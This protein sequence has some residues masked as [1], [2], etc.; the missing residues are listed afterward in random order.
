MKWL[1]R[2]KRFFTLA[3]PLMV[4]AN[5]SL[6]QAPPPLA[7]CTA[8]QVAQAV[9]P[10]YAPTETGGFVRIE[11]GFFSIAGERFVA[12]GVN[13]FPAQYPW[14]RFL[15]ATNP[16]TLQ[17]EFALLRDAGLNTLRIF[18]WYEALFDCPGSSVVPNVEN[19]VRLDGIIHEAAAHNLRLIL[20]LNDGPDLTQYPLYDGPSFAA[21][22]TEWIVS[23][24]RDEPAILAWDL[25]N[26]G[27]ID[28]GSRDG[29]F[30]QKFS[31]G[32]V[33]D[34]LAQE[35]ARVRRVDSNHLVTAGW[36]F[37]SLATEPYVDFLSFHH[38][39]DAADAAQRVAEMR[40]ATDKPILMEEVGY[41]T[42]VVT[43]EDQAENLQELID[44]AEG[45][46]LLGWL[47]W[48]AF[49]F[50]LTA[51]CWP[52]PCVDAENQEHH[53]GLWMADYVPK[54]AVTVIRNQNGAATP[55]E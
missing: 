49:D 51:T 47:V 21:L 22:Q 6:H 3:I 29:I 2:I 44:M 32:R 43:P 50:P 54:P 5:L 4:I 35:A 48:T 15:T 31:R 27:D 12:R 28:Y 14:R 25:R 17:T 8:E 23:R 52:P 36:L 1:P 18:L 42:Y 39:W 19:V 55:S 34:W 10:D 53:F 13:Y 16:Q 7:T 30:G 24:Y 46:G 11:D 40:A 41:S 37:D 38:W 45:E 9:L 20:T 33:L 26:E